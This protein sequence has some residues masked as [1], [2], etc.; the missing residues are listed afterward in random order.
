[1]QTKYNELDTLLNQIVQISNCDRNINV[2]ED[3]LF[4]KF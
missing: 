2:P 3:A 4:W 1:M